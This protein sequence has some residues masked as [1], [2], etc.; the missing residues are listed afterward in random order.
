M[1]KI[2]NIVVA[3]VVALAVSVGLL[4]T[5]GTP[6]VEAPQLGALAGPDIA[7]NYLSWGGIRVVHGAAKPTAASYTLCSFQS[8]AATS[9]IRSAVLQLTT[10][11][12]SAS[13]IYI[14]KAST[15]TATTTLLGSA[16]SLGAG[17]QLTL[18]ASSSPGSA[19]ATEI[20]APNNY[21]NFAINPAASTITN[22]A[23]QGVCHVVFEELSSL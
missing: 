12:T 22:L 3:G 13:T 20:I 23:P 4:T 10:S 2:T 17:A 1:G 8:P 21:V 19:A 6:K 16:Y 18:V 5:V 9:T 14:A 7:S 11:T 15:A